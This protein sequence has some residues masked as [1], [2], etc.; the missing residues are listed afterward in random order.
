M[1]SVADPMYPLSFIPWVFHASCNSGVRTNNGVI[2]VH[3]RVAI[4]IR[5]LAGGNYMDLAVLFGVGIPTVFS[6]L[7]QVVDAINKTPA[8]GP[9]YFPQ[10]E[11]QC[12]RAARGWK[13]C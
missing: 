7:W 6:I 4:A 12:A 13:V 5:M 2:S 3:L 10:T 1:T 8:V 11:E 9:F